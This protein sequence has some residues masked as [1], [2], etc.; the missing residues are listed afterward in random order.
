MLIL[1]E[2]ETIPYS[3][4]CFLKP[5]RIRRARLIT[6]PKNLEHNPVLEL[7][8]FRSIQVA[9]ILFS[10]KIDQILELELLSM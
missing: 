6:A 7:R 4:R 5:L 10:L 8:E 3:Q 1:E 2:A 9:E